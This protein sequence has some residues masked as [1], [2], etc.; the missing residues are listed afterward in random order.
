MSLSGPRL[1]LF[2]G[3]ALD[4]G[5]DFVRVRPRPRLPLRLPPRQ[6]VH[7]RR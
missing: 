5:G 2:D 7:L 4:G 6:A 1:S 3:G